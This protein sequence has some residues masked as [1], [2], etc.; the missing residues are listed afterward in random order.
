MNFS[1]ALLFL[2]SSLFS[3]P[4]IVNG[5]STDCPLTSD[6]D[7]K[8]DGSILLRQVIN[9]STSTVSVELEYLGIGWVGMAFSETTTMV[10]NTAI[11]GLPDAGTVQKY[12]LT[13]KD[14][15]GV[16]PASSDRQ[17]LT[18]T[19][20]VQ[21]GTS[22]I[23]KFT[24]P[25]IET[26]ETSVLTGT[27][28]INVAYGMT[29][30]LAYHLLR[31]PT[32]ATFT[33]CVAAGTTASPVAPTSPAPVAP[34]SPAP[35]AAP[36]AA[37]TAGAGNT[38]DLG[39][40]RTQISLPPF[41]GGQVV[42][43]FITDSVKQALTVT[44]EYAGLGWIGFAFSEDLF[45]PNSLAV[46]AMPNDGTGKPM[47][48]DIGGSKSQGAIVLASS[49]RQTLTEA[50]YSQNGTHTTMTF[51]KSLADANE[52]PILLAGNNNFLYAV[53]GS[54][55]FGYH[56]SRQPFS[57]DF[58]NAAAPLPTGGSTG[59]P[60]KSLWMAHGILM[61]ISWT[62]LVPLAVGTA[63]LRNFIAL[64][65]GQW[66]QVHRFL[67]SIAVACTIAGFAIAVHN[68]KD[69]QGNHFTNTIKHHKM[70]LVIFMFAI[71]QALSGMFRPHLPHKPEPEITDEEANGDK[72]PVDD[73][74]LKKSPQRIVFEIQH[75]LMGTTAM[76]MGWFNVDSGIGLYNQRFNG[77]D[78]A[79]VAW[80]V[81]GGIVGIVVI[82]YVYDRFLKKKA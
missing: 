28:M 41:G 16:L 53:G 13:I 33:E 15:S 42:L 22:T 36:V 6:I 81:T 46:I 76:V 7:L 78:L 1:K 66:F 26:G 60:N 56:A 70:G 52:V 79:P 3:I 31:L 10:P 20:I 73:T 37:P 8:G 72:P 11:I 71:L 67:N 44:M 29:N 54:N 12:D 57:F 43:T 18:N 17:T 5:Q 23:L 59:A 21:D 61:V 19:S 48:Y 38:V 50:S 27:N 9:P 2:L 49:D 32:T 39:N 64:P 55:A 34:T 14:I 25:L 47:K 58:D 40:G 35:V 74:P 51:T 4:T 45:M 82:C 63:V 68:I 24:K 75:R 80:A 69:E 30:T 62:I 77:N 65:A